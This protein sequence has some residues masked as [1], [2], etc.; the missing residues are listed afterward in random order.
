MEMLDKYEAKYIREKVVKGRG[1][2][3]IGTDTLTPE[4]LG[5]VDIIEATGR[6]I[7]RVCGKKILKGEWAIKGV[8]AWYGNVWCAVIVQLHYHKCIKQ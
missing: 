4:G 5:D 7:C 2:G 6:A 8:T 1:L 3:H